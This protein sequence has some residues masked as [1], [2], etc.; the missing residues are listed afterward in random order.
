MKNSIKEKYNKVAVPKMME[1]FSLKNHMQVPR[2]E[3][4]VVNVGVGKYLKDGNAVKEIGESLRAITGQ[5]PVATKARKSIAGFKIREGLEVGMCVTLRGT[6]K[7]DF[8]ERLVDVAIPRIRDFQ[9]LKA[10]SVD[11]NGN[12]NIGLKEHI[13]FPEISPENIKY[14]FS[15]QITVVTN[16]K[17]REKGEALFRF[18]NFPIVNNNN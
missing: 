10:S 2:I 12:L 13:V 5:K 9:G 6:R 11:A 7:W 3:K 18:L 14:I 15:F 4:V 16:A 8:I 17:N 1:T